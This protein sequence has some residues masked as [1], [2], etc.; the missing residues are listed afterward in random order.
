M[1]RTHSTLKYTLIFLFLITSLSIPAMAT[2]DGPEYPMILS[3]ELIIN[4]VDAPAGTIV[5]AKEGDK[6]LGTTT[7]QVDGE[8]GNTVL[9]KLP[10]TEP[11]GASFDLYIQLP[12]MSSGVKV[13]NVV[14]G[15]S[16]K[17]SNIDANIDT[18]TGYFDGTNPKDSTPATQSQKG[19]IEDIVFQTRDAAKESTILSSILI[20]GF[21][22]IAL[23]GYMRYKKR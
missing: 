9:N 19:G 2:T 21:I 11:D 23:F 8:Y 1:N 20:V 5:E 22:A 18:N 16:D 12:T 4:G 14:W 7:V 6:L 13:A 15:S 3:G 10:V 17:T